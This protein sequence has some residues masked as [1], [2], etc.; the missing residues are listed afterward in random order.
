MLY[1]INAKSTRATGCY[2]TNPACLNETDQFIDVVGYDEGEE[3]VID[4]GLCLKCA[5]IELIHC[6][7]QGIG[8]VELRVRVNPTEEV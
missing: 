1:T 8:D 4:S 3:V 6:D 2:C 5:A 7:M